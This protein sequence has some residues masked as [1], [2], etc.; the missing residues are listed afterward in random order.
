M[1]WVSNRVTLLKIMELFIDDSQ[2]IGGII[3]I[4]RKCVQVLTN[5]SNI[6]L[7]RTKEP[8]NFAKEFR[9]K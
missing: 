8:R 7:D 2:V 4:L 5:H 1:E 9:V 6:L 3:R